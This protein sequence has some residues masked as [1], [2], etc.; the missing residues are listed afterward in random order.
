MKSKF[1]DFPHSRG[2][3]LIEVL[4]AVLVLSVGLLGLA[5]LQGFSLQAG[6]HSYHRS[7]AVDL[8]YELADYARANRLR[9]L[10]LCGLPDEATYWDNVVS[11]RL[12]GGTL[13]F[14]V[15][16]CTTGEAEVTLSWLEGRIDEVDDGIE[17]VS[18][19]TRI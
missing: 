15:T 10:S 16:N 5:A 8:A 1:F 4:V 9:T 19:V 2:I 17:T 12:P 6:Q 3:S 14:D 13:N 18:F 11:E 7:Q